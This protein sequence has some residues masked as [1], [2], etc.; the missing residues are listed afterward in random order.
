MT[1]IIGHIEAYVLGD[2]YN[3]YM[4]R[5]DSLLTL[6]A[7]E[8]ANQLQFCIGFCGPDL[9]KIIKSCIAPK[10]IKELEYDQIKTA[11]KSYFEPKVN[12]L[13]ER[14]K[15]HSRQQKSEESVSDYIMEIKALSRT[16]DFKEHLTEA[17]RDQLVFG[18]GDG[19]IQS[20]LLRENDLTFDKA[21]SIAKNIELTSQQVDLM[22]HDNTVSV[23]ARTRLGSR[24][25]QN[26]NNR[27]QKKPRYANYQC[28]NCS[29][30]GHTSRNCRNKPSKGS[31]QRNNGNNRQ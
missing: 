22:Q 30:Y 19:K 11:L 21:C 25:N 28:F 23:F 20:A 3:D 13:A 6:N 29:Q 24:P 12:T 9:Y 8:E 10:T 31:N 16:C 4:E 14:F 18:V 15:F 1:A 17:L 27:D 5:M 26:G 7:V 2:D